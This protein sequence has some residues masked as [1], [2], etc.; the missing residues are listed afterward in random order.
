ME[1]EARRARGDPSPDASDD[2]F[3]SPL[4]KDDEGPFTLETSEMS[5]AGDFVDG[6]RA[7]QAEEGDVG[8]DGMMRLFQYDD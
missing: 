1:K 8:D 5:S 7:V 6:L 3:E 2:D 4:F